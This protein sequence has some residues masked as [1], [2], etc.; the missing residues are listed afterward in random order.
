MTPSLN[1]RIRGMLHGVALGDALG[2]PVEKLSAAQIR[3]RYG[4]VRSVM[5]GTG[6]L[7]AATT[8]FRCGH[9]PDVTV[10]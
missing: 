1:S 4:R 9:C 6:T 5:T 8:C 10:A 7:R 2:A 3:E